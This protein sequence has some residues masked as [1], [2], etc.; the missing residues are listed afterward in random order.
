[1]APKNTQADSIIGALR[2]AQDAPTNVAEDIRKST[3]RS[4]V[5]KGLASPTIEPIDDDEADNS[6]FD[7]VVE[8]F[9]SLYDSWSKKNPDPEPRSSRDPEQITTRLPPPEMAAREASRSLPT[10]EQSSDKYALVMKPRGGPKKNKMATLLKDQVFLDGIDRLKR[11]HPDLPVNKF[12][13]IIEGESA[14]NTDDR[15]PNSG[16][17][18]LWQ[19]TEDAL[20]DLK[21]RDLVPKDLT[22]PKIRYMGAGEQLDLYSKYLTRWGY[23]GKMSLGVLQAAPAKRKVKNKDQVIFKKGS[24]AWNQ[25]PGWRG[26]ESITPNSIDKYYFKGA[27]ER[28]LR[29]K[30]RPIS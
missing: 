8:M 24:K 23:D 15:N 26:P 27:L 7:N 2:E 4:G 14:G 9:S 10:A 29:P 1:M 13:Q 3:K 16:A 28:S 5:G 25:N 22:L 21:D 17:V 30:L 20:T 11:D 12:Y 18:G 6:V 19:V